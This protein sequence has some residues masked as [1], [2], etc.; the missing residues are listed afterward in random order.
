MYVCVVGIITHGNNACTLHIYNEQTECIYPLYDSGYVTVYPCSVVNHFTTMS[1]TL[2]TYTD[3]SVR[4]ETGAT[5]ATM[6]RWGCG[7]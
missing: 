6:M 5:C 1:Y 7:G 4:G 2:C 3:S